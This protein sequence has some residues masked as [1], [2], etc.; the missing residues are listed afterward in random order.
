MSVK[1][2]T[3]GEARESF[4]RRLGERYAPEELRAVFGRLM[5]DLLGKDRFAW[6][7]E[8]ECQ[9]SP[10]EDALLKRAIGE[11]EAGKPIQYVTGREVF[12]GLE[13]SVSEA[14]LIPRPETEGLVRLLLERVG[15]EEGK[16]AV[17]M[18]TGSG[19]IALSIARQRPDWVVWGLDVSVA[20]LEV[21][22]KNAQCNELEVE[23][24][25]WNLLSGVKADSHR[26]WFP[27]DILVSN[28]PYVPECERSGMDE[29]VH[30][31]EPGLALFVPDED[32]L[33]YYRH[34]LRFALEYGG[35]EV[36]LFAECHH[37]FA[38]SVARLWRESGLVGVEVTR[39]EYGR[40][41]YV[42]GNLSPIQ[43]DLKC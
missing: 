13:L 15:G 34:L 9:L 24:E 43:R 19:A 30:A 37:K 32:P 14:V 8:P 3:L 28:P 40:E 17:D 12:M 7:K 5:E 6:A 35:R 10:E 27:F 33:V 20:A 41:R 11:L 22:L 23:F 4:I 25:E 18:G 21:A 42:S 26:G 39:D 2:K 29:H 38:S 16:V 36:S 31:F 1:C